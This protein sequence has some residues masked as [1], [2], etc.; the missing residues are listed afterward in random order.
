MPPILCA[1][2]CNRVAKRDND[3][4]DR[5]KRFVFDRAAGCCERCG[6]GGTR[7]EFHHRQ[8]RSRGGD[9]TAANC[10]MLCGFGN[11]GGCHGWV[12]GNA[13]EA[14]A[15]GFALHAGDTPAD[16]P[17]ALKR[18]GGMVLL[19]EAGVK[20]ATDTACFTHTRKQV[21]S[22]CGVCQT[23]GTYL[24]EPAAP[25]TYGARKRG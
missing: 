10:V 2:A 25:D 22:T 21:D 19:D 15:A 4:S 18:W 7:F 3:F 8:Y 16:V 11:T 12:H 6:R 24:W 20:A 23:A 5:V 13:T 1:G 9:G 14:H 17:V